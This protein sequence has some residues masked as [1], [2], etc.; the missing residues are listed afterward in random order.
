M[1]RDWE[2]AFV[3]G[4]GELGFFK[5]YSPQS[6]A[7]DFAVEGAVADGLVHVG[8]LD[9]LGLFKVGNRPCDP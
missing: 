8:G 9:L 7:P 2:C 3:R 1:V 5:E 4:D 6:A